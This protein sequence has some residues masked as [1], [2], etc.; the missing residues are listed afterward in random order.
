MTITLF[1]RS[2]GGVTLRLEQGELGANFTALGTSLVIVRFHPEAFGESVHLGT[3]MPQTSSRC[4]STSHAEHQASN[5]YISVHG[6]NPDSKET[7]PSVLTSHQ[8]PKH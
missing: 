6:A 2:A 8:F 5:E 7:L 3:P 1:A 4:T